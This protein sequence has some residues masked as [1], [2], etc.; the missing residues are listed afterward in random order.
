MRVIGGVAR[1]RRLE[2]PAGWTVRPTGARLRESAF[3]ILEHRGAIER[4]RV[5]DLWA[6][7]GA[8]GIEALSRGARELVAVEAA[9]DAV[10]CLEANLAHC[11]LRLRA[12]VLERTVEQALVYLRAREPFDLVLAD[13]PWAVEDALAE[14]LG[15]LVAGGLVTPGGLVAVEHPAARPLPVVDGLACVRD[16]RQGRGAFGLYAPMRAAAPL[17][18]KM[19]E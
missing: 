6:G 13:P 1:G 14:A 10:R 11:D 18:Q 9:R 8:L 12:L 3:G 4:A 15:L 2:A 7:T 16:R 19:R 5:L 17:A